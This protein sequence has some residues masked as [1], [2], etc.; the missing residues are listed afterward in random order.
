MNRE[1]FTPVGGG[2]T[3]TWEPKQTGKKKENNLVPLKANDKSWVEGYYLGTEHNQGPDNNSQI[4]KLR[5]VK[6]GD[7]SH[8]S[9]DP[10]ESNGD[11][12]IWG[13]GVLNDK[14]TKVPVGTLVIV[15]WKGKQ[16]PKTPSGREFHNWELLQN[17][18][19]TINTG[20]A[21]FEPS[22]Q[23]E[24]SIAPSTLEGTTAATGAPTGNAEDDLPF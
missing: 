23:P 24:P 13:T 5:F 15:E 2:N 3:T 7:D 8:L 11:I 12:S 20:A 22:A 21:Q 14:F 6:A 9:G 10:A 16:Q 19:K 17:P 1:G 18:S 4:H